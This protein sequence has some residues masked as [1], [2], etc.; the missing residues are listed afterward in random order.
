MNQKKRE[1]TIKRQN[2]IVSLC[3]IELHY[4]NKTS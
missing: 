2:T 4:E 1:I 3:I